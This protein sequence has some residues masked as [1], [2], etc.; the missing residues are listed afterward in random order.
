MSADFESQGGRGGRGGKR[1][2]LVRYRS[3]TAMAD[4][5]QGRLELK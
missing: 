1:D 2:Q 5:L 4:G 3:F